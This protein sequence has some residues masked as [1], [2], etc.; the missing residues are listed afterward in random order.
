MQKRNFA[1]QN[2]NLIHPKNHLNIIGAYLMETLNNSA[3][4]FHDVSDM[5]KNTALPKYAL[6]HQTLLPGVIYVMVV[7]Q[8]TIQA[9]QCIENLNLQTVILDE[10]VSLLLTKP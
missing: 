3:I 5:G 9:V 7:I 1:T 2:R 8:P 6:R 10:Y 4:A